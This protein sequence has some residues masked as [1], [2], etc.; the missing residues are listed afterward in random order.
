VFARLFRADEDGNGGGGSDPPRLLCWLHGGP[1][2]QWQ[3][4]FMPRLA[5]WRSRGW[6]VLV[7]DHRGSTGHGRAY[8]QALN[9]RWG[10]LDV[11]DTIDVVAHAHRAGWATPARTALMGGSAGGFTVLGVLAARP[12]IAGAAV[13]SYPVTDLLDLAERSHR[14]ERHYTHRLVAPL[15]VSAADLPRYVERSPVTFAARIRVPMLVFHGDADPV[16][17]V[18]QSR[19]LVR[20]VTNGGGLVDLCVYEGEGHGFR[21]PVNQLDEYHR[22]ERFLDHHIGSAARGDGSPVSDTPHDRVAP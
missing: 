1:T 22:I 7:P 12:D 8:Q 20:R 2:D 19:E 4:T 17:P 14:F 21:Q 13:L 16:V 15:P 9:Q 3:V 10:E 5:F 11:A 6:N 18:E